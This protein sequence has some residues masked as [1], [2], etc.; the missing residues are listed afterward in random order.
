MQLLASFDFA[1]LPGCE[2]GDFDDH[3]IW[4]DE[5]QD[6][7]KKLMLVLA[8][9]CACFSLVHL[10]LLRL[11][12]LHRTSESSSKDLLGRLRGAWRRLLG[13]CLMSLA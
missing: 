4:P 5:V 10:P 1:L 11:E 2:I 7:M 13:S 8:W 6:F 12:P 3:W 9:H